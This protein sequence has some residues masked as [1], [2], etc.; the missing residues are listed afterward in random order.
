MLRKKYRDYFDL[1]DTQYQYRLICLLS[2]ELL[3]CSIFVDSLYSFTHLYYL[4]AVISTSGVLISLNLYLLHKTKNT[5]LCGHFTLFILFLTVLIANYLVRGI[6]P[7]LSAWFF[8][9]PILSVALSGTVG[10]LIYS[11]LSLLV[12]TAANIFTIHPYYS[13]PTME[14]TVINWVNHVLAFIF[15][16]STIYS[17]L[18]EN[19]RHEQALS[20]KNISLELEKE[21]YHYLACFDQLTQLPNREYFKLNLKAAID[22]LPSDQCITLFFMDLD[23]LKFINDDLGHDCGDHLLLETANRLRTCFAEN[24]FI[25]RL[26]GDEFTA[27]VVHSKRKNISNAMI[28]R[29]QKAFKE[30]FHF[31]NQIYLSS[32]SIGFAIYPNQANS[33][34]ELM[35][36]A[37]QM[38]YQEKRKKKSNRRLEDI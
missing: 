25:A 15:I 10:L 9:I 12:I 20:H 4:V 26:G 29:I 13:L 38:M 23:N 6:G 37:D 33:V 14:L 3:I 24:D 8:V 7:S 21:K 32:I 18:S 16:V 19:K 31:K 27:F 5:F 34:S 22:S 2:Y 30:G 1:S 35:R 28:K 36:L 17:L 11:T